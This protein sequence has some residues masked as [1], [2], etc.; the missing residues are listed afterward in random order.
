MRKYRFE[1]LE[2]DLSP[3]PDLAPVIHAESLADAAGKFAR[4]HGLAM[5]AYWDEP[6]FERQMDMI[7]RHDKGSVRCRI[8]W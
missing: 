8:F 4:K 5:P 6:S 2:S 7:F 3:L 1:L